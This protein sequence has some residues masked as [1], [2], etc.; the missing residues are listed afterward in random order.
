MMVR[1][2]RL[3][4]V[5]GTVIE[6]RRRS[7]WSVCVIG[8]E[9]GHSPGTAC[10]EIRRH[11][12]ATGYLAEAA[13]ADAAAKRRPSGRQPRLARDGPLFAEIARLLRLGW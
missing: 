12:V 5:D 7:G 10:H 13:E 1:S 4:L 2:R 3:K 9:L 8:R 11:C 6:L